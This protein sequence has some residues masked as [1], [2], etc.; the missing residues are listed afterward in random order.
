MKGATFDNEGIGAYS[1]SIGVQR[2]RK[3]GF[4]S[5]GFF[6]RGGFSAIKN[7]ATENRLSR[8]QRTFLG[9]V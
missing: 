9:L 2:L 7:A 3:H 4:F 8:D 6:L 1:G 5:N